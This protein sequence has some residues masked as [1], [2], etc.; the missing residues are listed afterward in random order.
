MAVRQRVVAGVSMV[1]A[2]AL[3][4]GGAVANLA[5]AGVSQAADPV[6]D[7]VPHVGAEQVVGTRRDAA[8][9]EQAESAVARALVERDS[10]ARIVAIGGAAAAPAI[11]STSRSQATIDPQEA[12]RRDLWL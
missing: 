7:S 2:A 9:A 12:V 6:S 10:I 11:D 1:A 8:K 5:P 3:I 4:I